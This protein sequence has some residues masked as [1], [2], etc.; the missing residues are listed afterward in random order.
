[1]KGLMYTIERTVY[2]VSHIFFQGGNAMK[3]KVER[4][5]VYVKLFDA[6]AAGWCKDPVT[7]RFFL[8]CQQNYANEMLKTQGY[9]FLNDVLDML[10]I[11]RTKAGHVVGWIYDKE[12]PYGDNCVDFGFGDI[13]PRRGLDGVTVLSFNVDGNI[14]DRN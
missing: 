8:E 4:A 9:L 11:A 5:P 10:G 1:M 7:N 14:M 3:V 2:S 13:C 6:H 12:N